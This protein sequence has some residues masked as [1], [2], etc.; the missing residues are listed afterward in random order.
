MLLKY[1]ADWCLQAFSLFNSNVVQKVVFPSSWQSHVKEAP[2]LSEL[3]VHRNSWITIGSEDFCHRVFTKAHILWDGSSVV[4]H[5]INVSSLDWSLSREIVDLQR[6]KRSKPSQCLAVL[7]LRICFC[8]CIVPALPL[9]PVIFISV[10]SRV[11]P[12]SVQVGVRLL[13]INFLKWDDYKLEIY[14]Y[15]W[16]TGTWAL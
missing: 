9:V 10:K 4:N 3:S 11:L 16:C 6:V 5:L 13:T 15:S 12:V 8:L 7:K 1:L 14:Q 2:F